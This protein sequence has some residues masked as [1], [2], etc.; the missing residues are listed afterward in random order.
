MSQKQ[1]QRLG[2]AIASTILSVFSAVSLV[3]VDKAQA[4][5]LTYNVQI[6][7]GGGSGFFKVDNSSLTG[8]GVEYVTVSEAMFNVF[9]S[10]PWRISDNYNYNNL[11]ERA[12]AVFYQGAFRGLST[13]D[14]VNGLS[15]EYYYPGENPEYPN[16]GGWVQRGSASW[17]ITTRQSDHPS[18]WTSRISGYVEG[19]LE[20]RGRTPW[21]E[22][23]DEYREDLDDAEVYYTLVDTEPSPV[24]EPLTAGGTAL[25]LAGLSWLKHKKKMAA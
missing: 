23:Y 6:E 18:M 9:P 11:T 2:S 3:G 20:I 4:A 14:S 12:G 22:I 10:G 21:T 13:G 1:R 15:Y 17:E 8:I 16:G 7:N 24:P 19:R 5:V 25:A